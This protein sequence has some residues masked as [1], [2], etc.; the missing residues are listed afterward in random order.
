[1]WENVGIMADGWRFAELTLGQLLL[2]VDYLNYF[3]IWACVRDE[4]R[5]EFREV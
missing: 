5:D 4:L 2:D 3:L 1:M